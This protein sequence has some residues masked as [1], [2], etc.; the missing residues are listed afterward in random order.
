MMGVTHFN[1]PIF[2]WFIRE[3]I[4]AVSAHPIFVSFLG[5]QY[6]LAVL[7]RIYLIEHVTVLCI[8]LNEFVLYDKSNGDLYLFMIYLRILSVA[9]AMWLQVIE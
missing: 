2:F 9:Q 1:I 5:H 8:Y 6:C 3:I 4:R 7:R